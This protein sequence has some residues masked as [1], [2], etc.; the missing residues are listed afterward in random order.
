MSRKLTNVGLGAA[1]GTTIAV[2]VMGDGD[3]SGKKGKKATTSMREPSFKSRLDLN[4][5]P[6]FERSTTMRTPLGEKLGKDME[7]VLRPP[8][9]LGENEDSD[10]FK[11]GTT[12]DATSPA[13]TLEGE[14][15]DGKAQGCSCR[16]FRYHIRR[17]FRTPAS[18]TP[19]PSAASALQAAATDS[20]PS[21]FK[22]EDNAPPPCLNKAEKE[23]S[24]LAYLQQARPWAADRSDL[25]SQRGR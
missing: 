21:D 20:S 5:L 2:F 23:E 19:I 3:D 8:K 24:P 12:S 1:I 22:D 10:L 14:V 6:S 11:S 7:E 16:H 17:P 15:K 18:D 9:D 4:D 25:G 13:D